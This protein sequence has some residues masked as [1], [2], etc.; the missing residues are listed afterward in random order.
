MILQKDYTLSSKAGIGAQSRT[1]CPDICPAVYQPV[2]G[3]ALV[4]GKLVRCEFSNGCVMGVS[5]CQN[6][7]RFS[8]KPLNECAQTAPICSEFR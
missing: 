7:I 1:G 3:E 2:C 6:N 4:N 5:S 8:E